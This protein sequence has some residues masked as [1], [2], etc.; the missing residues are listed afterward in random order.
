[1]EY[2]FDYKET[3]VR[4]VKIEAK[5]FSEAV[6][7]LKNKIDNED[8]VLDSSDFVGGEIRMPLEENS[9]PQLQ[10]YGESV[11]NKEGFELVVDIW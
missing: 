4:R 9:W 3:L 5:S 10:V 7:I 1:M 2:T 6:E 11:V 8:I